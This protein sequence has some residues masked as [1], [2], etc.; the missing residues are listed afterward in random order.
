MFPSWIFGEEAHVFG[1]SEWVVFLLANA[2]IIGICAP[3][4]V[5]EFFRKGATRG[6]PPQA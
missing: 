2:I 1:T 6:A 5:A 3:R 4:V